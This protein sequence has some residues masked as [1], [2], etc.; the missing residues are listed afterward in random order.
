MTGRQKLLEIVVGAALMWLFLCGAL[1]C[2]G[3]WRRRV[4]DGMAHLK[5]TKVER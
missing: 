1:A 4:G 3:A 2:W 5:R